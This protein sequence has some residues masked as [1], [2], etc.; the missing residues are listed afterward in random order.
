MSGKITLITPPDI[1][2]NGNHSTLFIHPSD[3]EQDIISQWLG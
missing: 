3:E 1:Y 2:E